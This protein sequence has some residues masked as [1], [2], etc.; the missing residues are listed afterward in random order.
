MPFIK[1]GQF[2]EK[3]CRLDRIKPEI[4]PDQG[5]VIFGFCAMVSEEGRSYFVTLL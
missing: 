2:Y 1:M 5:M 3:D 4:A